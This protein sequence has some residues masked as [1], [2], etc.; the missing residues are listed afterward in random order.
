MNLS[1]IPGPT[2]PAMNSELAPGGFLAPVFRRQR[3]SQFTVW[4]RSKLRTGCT[5]GYPANTIFVNPHDD[6]QPVFCWLPGA[7]LAPVNPNGHPVQFDA[8]LH[9]VQTER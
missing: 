8:K 5:R 9:P 3:K 2:C 4:R 6:N 1:Q 7:H